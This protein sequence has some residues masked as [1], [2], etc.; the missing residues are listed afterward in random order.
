MLLPGLQKTDWC[1]ATLAPLQ[2]GVMKAI[3]ELW[4]LL[5]TSFPINIA[6]LLEQTPSLSPLSCHIYI[7]CFPVFYTCHPISFSFSLFLWGRLNFYVWFCK[8]YQKGDD[9]FIRGRCCE[10]KLMTSWFLGPPNFWARWCIYKLF[11][12][13][14]I[15]R[16]TWKPCQSKSYA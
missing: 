1:L 16:K 9:Y 10:F 5:D 3:L 7:A 13:S 4:I 11:K 8:L 12:L 14:C 15:W 6:P 2:M